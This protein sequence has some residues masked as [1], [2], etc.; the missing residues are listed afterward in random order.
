M[1]K[2][3]Y[4]EALYRIDGRDGP[5]REFLR[6]YPDDPNAA[7]LRDWQDQAETGD[8]LDRLRH[9]A[10]G[11]KFKKNYFDWQKVDPNYESQ[12][13]EAMRYEDYGDVHYAGQRWRAAWAI[14]DKDPDLRVAKRLAEL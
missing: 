3:E 1:E 12:A 9:N 7:K 8:L 5:V 6:R 4:I 13:F 14:A 11:P 2:R 10:S